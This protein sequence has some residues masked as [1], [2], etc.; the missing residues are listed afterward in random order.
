MVK[1]KCINMVVVPTKDD[2]HFNNGSFNLK[3]SVFQV[4]SRKAEPNFRRLAL[5]IRSLV[6][7]VL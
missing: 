6:S 7:F 3:P 4:F 5:M 2:G 1:M